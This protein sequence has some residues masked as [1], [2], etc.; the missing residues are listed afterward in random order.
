MEKSV[1]KPFYV[2]SLVF[3]VLC[4][5]CVAGCSTARDAWDK[6]TEVYDEYIDPK[7]EIDLERGSRLSRHEQF[8]ANQ[9]SRVDQHVESVLRALVPQDTYPDP[10]WF[11]EMML[12]FPWLTAVMA[13]D[14]EGEILT[15]QPEFAMKSIDPLPL[16]DHEWSIFQRDV[17]GFAQDTPVGPELIIAG[18]FFRDGQWQGLLVVHFDPRSLA[19]HASAADNLALLASGELLWS[20]LDPDA[21][22]Q[23]TSIDWQNRL[24]SDVQGKW[25]TKTSSFAWISRP[26]GALHLIY[27]VSLPN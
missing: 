20:S 5:F 19:E 13:V 4:L 6:G 17:Q 8:L 23:I 14:T 11:E 9:F 1:F 21:T 22:S 25:S 24:K 26:I 16:L 2:F 27:A 18:P 12:R 10:A 3:L 7:P 15:R